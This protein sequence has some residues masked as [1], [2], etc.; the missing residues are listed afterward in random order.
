MRGDVWTEIEVILRIHE[1]I[2]HQKWGKSTTHG[3]YRPLGHIPD[4]RGGMLMEIFWPA[5]KGLGTI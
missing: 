1:K 2:L 3:P 4:N 5:S